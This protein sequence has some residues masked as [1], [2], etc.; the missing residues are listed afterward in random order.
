LWCI[1]Q[2]AREVVIDGLGRNRA[3]A[4]EAGDGHRTKQ[5]EDHHRSPE[6]GRKTRGGSRERVARVVEGFVTP[7]P[8]A[9]GAVPDDAKRHRRDGGRKDRGRDMGHALRDRDLP[10]T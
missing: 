6:I 3:H 8:L 4:E 9:E 10:K 5:K 1:V 7:D 2:P